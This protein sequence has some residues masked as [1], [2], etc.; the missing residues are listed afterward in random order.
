MNHSMT[1]SC[2]IKRMNLRRNCIKK[3]NIKRVLL[4]ESQSKSE[5]ELSGSRELKCTTRC[6]TIGRA[7]II[8][9]SGF[10]RGDF[11]LCVL[12]VLIQADS[13]VRLQ[14]LDTTT[15]GRSGADRSLTGAGRTTTDQSSSWVW[16]TQRATRF[17]NSFLF[18]RHILAASIFAGDSSLGSA[19][20][21]ITETNIV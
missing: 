4:E 16:R 9:H 17:L 7:I 3:Q 14:N 13:F 6:T 15:W 18:S 2:R 21:E 12:S 1:N 19:S 20:I 8:V 10:T 11:R 5:I